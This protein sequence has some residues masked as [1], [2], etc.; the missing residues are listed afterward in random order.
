MILLVDD[1]PTILST[2]AQML[3]ALEYEVV[4]AGSGEEALAEIQRDHARFALLIS[5]MELGDNTGRALLEQARAAGYDG[6][7]VVMT[8]YVLDE[9]T[10]AMGFDDLLTKPFRFA[11]LKELVDTYVQ[12]S[13]E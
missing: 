8:G 7:A 13:G 2:A 5:D 6:P 1:D 3:R 9:E 11:R 4:E 12:P 10:A